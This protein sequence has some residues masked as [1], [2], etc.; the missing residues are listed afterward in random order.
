M[1][2]VGYAGTSGSPGIPE[3][4]AVHA[5]PPIQHCDFNA[6]AV[7]FEHARAPVQHYDFNV[8][9]ISFEPLSL[10]RGAA[11]PNAQQ[12]FQHT[13]GAPLCREGQ[14]TKSQT[15]NKTSSARRQPNQK[16]GTKVPG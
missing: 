2:T 8:N 4:L 12:T 13:S 3:P 6:N 10:K 7:P 9:A 14:A 16:S 15:S 5:R 11:A 1:S